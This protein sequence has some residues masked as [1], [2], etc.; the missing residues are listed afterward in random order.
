MG[1]LLTVKE[2]SEF[3]RLKP[4]TLYAYAERRIIP[5]VKLGSRLFFTKEKLERWIEDHSVESIAGGPDTK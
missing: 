3:T 2:A 1:P 4:K 5:H